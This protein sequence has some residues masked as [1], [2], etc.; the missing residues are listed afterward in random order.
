MNFSLLH[1]LNIAFYF[2]YIDTNLIKNPE[3]IW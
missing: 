3:C 2:L 1:T